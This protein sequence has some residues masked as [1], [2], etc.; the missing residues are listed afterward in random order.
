MM[1]ETKWWIF[2]RRG[3]EQWNAKGF[4]FNLVPDQ[5]CWRLIFS[6][7]L[8]TMKNLGSFSTLNFNP[9]EL[10]I[11]RSY[12]QSQRRVHVQMLIYL[13]RLLTVGRKVYLPA[14]EILCPSLEQVYLYKPLGSLRMEIIQRNYL[15]HKTQAQ[16][17]RVHLCL[18]RWGVRLMDSP[19]FCFISIS[20]LFSSY[21]AE[22]GVCISFIW[23]VKDFQVAWEECL[24]RT[25]S[26]FASCLHTTSRIQIAFVVTKHIPHSSTSQDPRLPAANP[27]R[28]NAQNLRGGSSSGVTCSCSYRKEDIP[29][30][31][32]K[33]GGRMPR[34]K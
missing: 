19:W 34:K 2:E 11:C 17:A 31:P 16:K 13:L 28:C 22:I 3:R 27:D 15:S 4:L 20:F 6:V 14:Q 32:R 8:L 21:L 24:I 12:S 23:I 5:Y 29:C 10:I 7:Y 26:M 18:R 25:L 9:P 30:S 1:A 33:V